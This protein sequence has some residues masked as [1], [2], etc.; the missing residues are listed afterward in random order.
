MFLTD[1]THKK[2][3][4]LFHTKGETDTTGIKVSFVIT[5]SSHYLLPT[6]TASLHFLRLGVREVLGSK[7]DDGQIK[8]CRR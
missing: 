8:V 5:N 3:V 7:T 2:R 6:V 1:I 4:N